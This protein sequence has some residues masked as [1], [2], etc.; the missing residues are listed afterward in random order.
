MSV[1]YEP[2]GAAREYGELAVNLYSGGCPHKCRY[3]YVPG[4]LHKSSEQWI[5][6]PCVLRPGVN[7]QLAEDLARWRWKN[8][9]DGQISHPQVFMCFTGDPFP[10]GVDHDTTLVAIE[11]C[12]QEGFGVRLL[13]KNG[14]GALAALPLLD[15]RDAFGVTVVTSRKEQKDIWEPESPDIR[16]RLVALTQARREG[17]PTWLSIEPVVHLDDAKEIIG[18][19]G[20][21]ADEIKIGRLNHHP[22]GKNFNWEYIAGDLAALCQQL[23]FC[24]TLKKGLR[25]FVEVQ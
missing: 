3:C 21:L 10:M 8:D 17:I 16:A 11:V 12:H 4:C 2:R 1:L 19:W 6:E 7:I 22:E 18:D 24:Y 13:T 23:G 5:A 9:R 14:E 15:G 25:E 20:H